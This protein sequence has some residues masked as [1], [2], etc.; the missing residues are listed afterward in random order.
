MTH[1]DLNHQLAVLGVLL[2]ATELSPPA[3]L[4]VL[5]YLVGLLTGHPQ[6]KQD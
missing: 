3:G 5:A 2:A 1:L 4:I 6:V